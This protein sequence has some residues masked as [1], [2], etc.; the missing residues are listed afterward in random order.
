MDLPLLDR[1]R[2]VSARQVNLTVDEIVAATLD[3]MELFDVTSGWPDPTQARANLLR[4][5]GEAGGRVLRRHVAE[6]SRLRVGRAGLLG[7]PGDP[8]ITQCGAT[9]GK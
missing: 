2:E 5:V 3:A 8:E 9:V 7:E 4:L 1:L 6:C